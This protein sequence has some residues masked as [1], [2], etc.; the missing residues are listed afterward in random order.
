MAI[1]L[2]MGTVNNKPI[3]RWEVWWRTVV[4]LHKKLDDA[5]TAAILEEMP[6]MMIKAVP[7]AVADDGDYEEKP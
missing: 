4:G 3:V 6:P 7:V 2:A 1:D 5:L